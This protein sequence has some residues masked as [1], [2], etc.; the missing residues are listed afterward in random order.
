M[1][2]S[3]PDILVTWRSTT[4]FTLFDMT[5]SIIIVVIESW[6]LFSLCLEVTKKRK[7][8]NWKHIDCFVRQ[9]LNGWNEP[10]SVFERSLLPHEL[11]ELFLKNTEMER[12]CDESTNYTRLKGNHMFA[13]TVEKLKAFLAIL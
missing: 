6:I 11:F 9:Q 1:H 7:T 3:K 8:A 2:F 10:A 12:I 13:M 5:F 4:L